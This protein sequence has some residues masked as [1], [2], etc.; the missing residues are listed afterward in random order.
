MIRTAIIG[1][2]SYL[3]VRVFSNVDLERMVDTSDEWISSRTGIKTR[4]IAGKGEYT[5]VISSAAG[6]KALDAA[7]LK[8]RDLHLIIVGTM[9]PDM[10]MPSAACLVQKELDAVN[11]FAFDVNAAC[12]GFLYALTIADKFIQADPRQKILVIGGETLSSRVNWQ[13]RNTCVLFG[14]GAGACLVTGNTEGRGIYSS[15][16]FS[17]G[18]LWNLLSMPGAPSMNPDLPST[19]N[20]DGSY[21]RM[22]GP[23][24]FKHAIRAMEQAVLAVL[25]DNHLTIADINL[26][27]PHQANIRI[28]A[29]LAERLK[30][31]LEKLFINIHK[32]GNT[33]AASVPI[34]IDE[35]VRE[36]RLK[37]GD[38]LLLCAF[39]GGFTGGATIIK[40]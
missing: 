5:S 17:D 37:H 4:H 39:G 11:A 9:T 1:T 31:P 10:T 15:H 6:K 24:V 25:A 34:A 35:A 30:V 33:S 40:W 12:S 14:D 18:R 13:D 22:Q 29:G 23:D 7:G 20:N 26:V 32:Y 38:F 21:I 19:H 36:G 28:I 16:L 8:A 3:P 27:I 2:G